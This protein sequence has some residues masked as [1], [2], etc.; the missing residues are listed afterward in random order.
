MSPLLC[1][2]HANLA[3]ALC[4]RSLLLLDGVILK[5]QDEDQQ[6]V[7]GDVHEKAQIQVDA[8]QI[9]EDKSTPAGSTAPGRGQWQWPTR[10][11]YTWPGP[12]IAA[13]WC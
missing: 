3:A 7:E 11:F 12:Q 4:R 13:W 10:Y 5:D 2:C 8:V 9:L 1:K 6:D